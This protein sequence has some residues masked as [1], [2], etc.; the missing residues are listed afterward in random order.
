MTYS[1]VATTTAAT[2]SSRM[3]QRSGLFFCGTATSND[4]GAAR[5]DV[6][7]LIDVGIERIRRCGNVEH[8]MQE[9]VGLQ[10][11]HEDERGGPRIAD[12]HDAGGG[13]A[14]KIVGDDLQ[15]PARRR[16]LAASVEGDH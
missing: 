8:V 13:G 16:V 12:A 5:P 15:T 14:A 9:D 4:D 6:D 3:I 1:S 10:R 11:S 2:I 7:Q